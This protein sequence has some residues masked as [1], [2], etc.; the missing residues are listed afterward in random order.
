MDRRKFLSGIGTVGTIGAVA[1]GLAVR[2]SSATKA[3]ASGLAQA[4]GAGNQSRPAST[5]A[6]TNKSL[7]ADGVTLGY[8]PGSAGIFATPTVERMMRAT[9]TG[10]RWAR[11][12]ASLA[13]QTSQSAIHSLFKVSSLVDLSIGVLRR[14][15]AAASAVRGLDIVAHFAMDDAP[16]FAPF[17]AWRYEATGLS[18]APK[19]TQP[20]TFSARIPDHVALE[21]NY[22]LNP[23]AI[24]SGIRSAGMLYLPIGANSASSAG[25]ATGLYVFASPSA[26]TGVQPDLS[27]YVFSGDVHTPLADPSGRALDFDY[28]TLA[29]RPVAI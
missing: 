25:L 19:S 24:A 13:T 18:T 5:A 23:S 1:T 11:W 29:I 16:Y 10:L 12:D 6:Q 14:A 17:S 4:A 26:Y 27:A 2:E 9:A 8:L 15:D 7:A 22:A 28:L 21:V 20:I 3:R